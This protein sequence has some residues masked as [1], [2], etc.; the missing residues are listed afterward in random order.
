MAKIDVSTIEGYAD[1]SAEDKLKALEGYDFP[2]PDYSGY[3]RKDLFDKKAH[4]L[5]EKTKQL[6][7]KLSDDEKKAAEQKELQDRYDSLVRENTIS[8]HKARYIA[9]GYDEKLAEETATAVADGDFEKVIANEKK[10][11]EAHEKRVK[12]AILKDTPRPE[13]GSGDKTV[14]R[15]EFN[16]MSY[17][18]QLK[19]IKEHPNWKTELK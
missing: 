10:N 13:G 14:T 16:K 19:Y 17:E 5:S 3:V 15:D 12:D 18:D 11:L 7:D 6:N 9:L 4:E 1:M 2:D 8:K